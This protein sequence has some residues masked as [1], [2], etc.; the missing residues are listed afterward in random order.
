[1]NLVTFLPLAVLALVLTALYER[2]NNL[3][4]PIMAHALFNAL[5][6]AALFLIEQT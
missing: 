2:T 5:N 1:M 4:A 6:F 3:L